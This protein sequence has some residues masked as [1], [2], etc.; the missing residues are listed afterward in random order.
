MISDE[1]NQHSSASRAEA[2]AVDSWTRFG[3]C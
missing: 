1:N 3:F 2:S